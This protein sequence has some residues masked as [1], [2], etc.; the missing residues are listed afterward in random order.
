MREVV[1]RLHE[2]TWH[3]A[4]SLREHADL[5]G[6]GDGSPRLVTADRAAHL[7]DSLVRETDST[8]VLQ[9]L[10]RFDLPV[11]PQA[12]AHSM[13][14]GKNLA[15]ELDRADWELLGS[16]RRLPD[17]KG[18]RI[19]TGLQVVAVQEELHANLMPALKAAISQV[20]AALVAI[21]VGPLPPVSP[22]P[23]VVGP[24]PPDVH[25]N[26]IELDVEGAEAELPRLIDAIRAALRKSPRG[27][28][29]VRWWIE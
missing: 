20:R 16:A 1:A 2:P 15:I 11:E 13:T 23:I 5:L 3:L 29:K 18:E 28:L 10:A 21:P 9:V 27:R 4:S 12:L 25:V 22:A 19:L 24:R 7:L 26:D 6:I 17:G 8:V 14:S